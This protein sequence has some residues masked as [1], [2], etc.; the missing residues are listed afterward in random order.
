MRL[1]LKQS[2]ITITLHSDDLP[3]TQTYGQCIKS[4]DTESLLDIW[5]GPVFSQ[6]S[7]QKLQNVCEEWL[8]IT[9]GYIV[10]QGHT[11]SRNI[12]G[13]VKDCLRHCQFLEI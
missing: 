7:H 6:T 13:I 10:P 11:Q 8:V 9:F 5:K 3:P 2:V 12:S 4:A 1:R